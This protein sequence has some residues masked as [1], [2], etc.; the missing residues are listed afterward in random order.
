MF[1]RASALLVP[2]VALVSVVAAAPEPI[3]ARNDGSCSSGT[4]Q[5]CQST[6]SA[7]QESLNSLTGLLGIVAEIPLVG[8]LLGLNCSPITV[9]GLGTGANCAQQ[10]VCCQNTQFNLT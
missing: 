8:P 1:I 9:V 3:V 10:T 7:T 4:L 2:V 5:C 6:T